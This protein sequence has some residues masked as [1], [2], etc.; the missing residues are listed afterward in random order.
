VKAKKHYSSHLKYWVMHPVATIVNIIR[1]YI[2]M[3]NLHINILKQRI[4]WYTVT[5][6][7]F[8]VLQNHLKMAT[9][10]D[11]NMQC[12]KC[13]IKRAPTFVAYGG[14]YIFFPCFI[15]FRPNYITQKLLMQTCSTKCQQ[16]QLHDL[17]YVY[18]VCLIETSFM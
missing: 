6:F 10:R 2:F 5:A 18:S 3:S 11:R 7:E 8:F 17:S 14:I 9:N 12:K 16:T 1:F 15:E 4:R 13:T